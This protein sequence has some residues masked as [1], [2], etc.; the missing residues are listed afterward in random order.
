MKYDYLKRIVYMPK[1]HYIKDRIVKLGKTENMFFATMWFS[2][3]HKA[4]YKEL[5]KRVYGNG[6]VEKPLLR[7]IAMI[8]RRKKIPIKT[9]Y[10]YGYKLQEEKKK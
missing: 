10:K 1:N 2:R 3:G 6:S 9:V 4:T 8:L 5:Y 7:N